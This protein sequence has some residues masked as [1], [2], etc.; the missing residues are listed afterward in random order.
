[1]QI[2]QAL[3]VIILL[4]LSISGCLV[5]VASCQE[6]QASAIESD[7]LIRVTLNTPANNTIISQFD[8]TFTYTPIILGS[9]KFHLANLVIN[10]GTGENGGFWEYYKSNQTAI[11]NAT[12][13]S[14][15]YQFTQNG[16]YIWNIRLYNSTHSII[17]SEK[18]LDG[19][20]HTTSYILTV[21]V[22]EPTPTPSPTP[23]PTPTSTSGSTSS[24]TPTLGDEEPNNNEPT[25]TNNQ[26]EPSSAPSSQPNTESSGFS[27]VEKIVIY[28]LTLLFIISLI[29]VYLSRKRTTAK[30][31]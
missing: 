26:Q 27:D 31:Y 4:T 1:M 13:N 11:V 30:A 2:K 14:I 15:A 24:P 17:A 18:S 25:P 23:T 9:D 16:T 28:V 29:I 19:S 20:E 22:Y 10:S 3:T 5:L 21:A 12:Q 6:G 8:C 7:Q